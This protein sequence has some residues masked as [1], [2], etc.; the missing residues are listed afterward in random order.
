MHFT[1]EYNLRYSDL[2]SRGENVSFFI[3]ESLYL[4]QRVRVCQSVGVSIIPFMWISFRWVI[5]S[6]RNS[7]RKLGKCP[8]LR[9]S[10]LRDH[11]RSVSRD[12]FCLSS[13]IFHKFFVLLC[14]SLR[15]PYYIVPTT[16]Y[17]CK[18][19]FYLSFRILCLVTV[20]TLLLMEF[21]TCA[22]F[23]TVPRTPFL[24]N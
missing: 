13:F 18:S 23:L 12:R 17:Y 4:T 9:P 19:P 5:V 3:V 14:V 15:P 21:N 7:N 22:S 11:P 8:S 2:K 1:R 16:V 24:W 6:L 10:Y 20:T